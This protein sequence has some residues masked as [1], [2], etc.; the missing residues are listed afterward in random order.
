MKA[1]IVI[2]K[3]KELKTRC[4]LQ[5]CV[6]K[7]I[8][9]TSLYEVESFKKVKDSIIRHQYLV[10]FN[11]ALRTLTCTCQYGTTEIE[12]GIIDE[13][14]RCKHILSVQAVMNYINKLIK[15][16][17]LSNWNVMVYAKG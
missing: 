13:G 6:V 5:Y 12:T 7:E 10:G 9:K 3:V 2:A 15:E 4:N 16:I 17:T 1:Y 8:P 14:K 11:V